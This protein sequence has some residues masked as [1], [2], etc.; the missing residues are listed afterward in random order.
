M[1]LN[2]DVE[3]L[4]A[5]WLSSMLEYSQDPAVGAVGAKLLYPNGRL[6]HVGILIGVCGVAA[7]AFHQ[8]HA[9]TSGYAGSAVVAR[10]CSAVTAA[11]LM[12]R[13]AVFD[14]LGG[15]VE[16]LPVDFNDV[17]FAFAYARQATASCSH[18]MRS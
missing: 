6:Q 11:C 9:S 3:V 16:D 13:K 1:L 17:D 15:F 8:C 18:R 4:T 12:T 10:N 14:E 5:G 2:D 7:H